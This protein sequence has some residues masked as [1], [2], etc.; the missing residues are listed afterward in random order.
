[1]IPLFPVVRLVKSAKRLPLFRRQGNVR[2]LLAAGQP[3]YVVNQSGES[4]ACHAAHHVENPL[5]LLGR[6]PGRNAPVDNVTRQQ[7][8]RTPRGDMKG[9]GD[10]LVKHRLETAQAPRIMQPY[11][12]IKIGLTPALRRL[13]AFEQQPHQIRIHRV[14]VHRR[15]YA[16]VHKKEFPSLP[17]GYSD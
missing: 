2:P 16:Q 13:R 6:F 3:L 11:I 17:P 10:L 9:K 1:M 5:P 15:V 4:A 8:E 14:P 7:A 12:P